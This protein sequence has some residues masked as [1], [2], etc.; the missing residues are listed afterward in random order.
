MCALLVV[1]CSQPESFV[2]LLRSTERNP[3]FLPSFLPS[4]SVTRTDKGQLY[5][6]PTWR[7]PVLSSFAVSSSSSRSAL[8]PVR[9]SVRP[10]VRR[11]QQ[12]TFARSLVRSL[13]RS[14]V[15][16]FVRLCTMMRPHPHQHSASI[17]NHQSS[18]T[19]IHT[20]I[21]IIHSFIHSFISCQSVSQSVSPSL[22]RPCRRTP[23]CSATPSA[24]CGRG[25][26]RTRVGWN[27]VGSASMAMQWSA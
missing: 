18:S 11:S 10:S 7:V 9:R 13:V 2:L 17:I 4:F 25:R 27:V 15:R 20:C 23:F 5:L 22:L 26:R 3:P 24:V 1:S 19:Y 16:S 12:S 14:F 8:P 21:S 6:F